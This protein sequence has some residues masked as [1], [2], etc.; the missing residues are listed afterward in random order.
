[1]NLFRT[2]FIGGYECADMINKKR[3][4]V[5]LLSATGHDIHVEEDYR[6][7]SALG[8]QTV[9][10]GI[11]WSVV[12]KEPFVYDFSEVKNRISVAQKLGIQQLWDIC[13]FGYPGDLVP[14]SPDFTDRLVSVCQ[15]FTRLYRT[16][17]ED[18]LIITP[19]NEI[20]F[21]TYLSDIAATTPFIRK[22]GAQI[23]YHLCKAVIQS[24]KA[25]KAIDPAAKVMMVEPLIKVHPKNGN[26]ITPRVLEYNEGQ[27]EAMDMI[28]G[29]M[30]PELGGRPDLMDLVGFNYYYNN[31]WELRGRGVCWKKERERRNFPSLLKMAAERY[32]KP[33]VLSETGHY[34][35]ERC[36]WM[37]QITEECI[38]AMQNGV[39]LR[40]ICIY[41]VLDRPDWDKMTYIP[42]GIWGYNK[43]SLMRFEDTEYLN[44]VKA[45]MEQIEN[46][47]TT[48]QY[49]LEM[50][51]SA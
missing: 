39:D 6:Q 50:N 30:N 35:E 49:P 3:Q 41:P 14:T 10:E 24:I 43:K 4:R 19:V 13:H 42:C 5:N 20:S 45:C 7:L 23:K 22:S 51:S 8:M 18:P 34:K 32:G 2:F 31:Q 25:V 21:L 28:T 47:L 16:M 48:T 15:A 33:V 27:F 1:M 37:L 17:T 38:E 12:E 44:T 11:R 40:G 26:R 29:R 36:G 9:R 46:Y